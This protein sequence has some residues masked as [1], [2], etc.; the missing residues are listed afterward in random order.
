MD[1]IGQEHI[2]NFLT[3]Q[4]TTNQ[5]NSA[6]LFSGITHLGKSVLA[7][8][9]MQSL[10]CQKNKVGGCQ[11]CQSCRM[12]VKNLLPD[13]HEIDVLPEKL[14][15]TIDQIRN[16]R[17]RLKGKS[18]S[19]SY[20]TIIIKQA[21]LLNKSAANALLKVIEEPTDKT[22]F[23]LLDNR[24]K[25]MLP[26]ITSRC[27]I[28]NFYPPADKTIYKW[29]TAKR[30]LPDD[31]KII[32]TISAGRPVLAQNYCYKI[33][34]LSE[35]QNLLSDMLH[36]IVSFKNT[37]N[38]AIQ[39]PSEQTSWTERQRW[40]VNWLE[41]Y[42]LLW[43]NLLLLKLNIITSINFI[44]MPKAL[45]RFISELNLSSIVKKLDK[46]NQAL[47][48]IDYN[49]PGTLLVDNLIYENNN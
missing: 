10:V 23:V 19:N 11:Q 36:M 35:K 3:R 16:I 49:V 8:F 43:R 27:Q 31:A 4:L 1:I 2:V 22:V 34:D 45:S 17:E 40:A 24:T 44:S 13:S 15:I 14:D 30:V 46:I 5:V 26:T 28:I 41:D 33:S 20:K 32:T 25:K 12:Y 48:D 21:E 18:F 47:I 9:F 42:K 38:M 39:P 37:A 6:Y 29:L 7:K